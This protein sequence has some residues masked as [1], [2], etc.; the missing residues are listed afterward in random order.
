MEKTELKKLIEQVEQVIYGQCPT[1]KNPSIVV[2]KET[3]EVEEVELDSNQFL[4]GYIFVTGYYYD[5]K[6]EIT[7]KIDKQE[8][9]E[10]LSQLFEH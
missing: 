7:Y 9:R 3:L 10:C 8:L 6:N 4:P 5:P 1:E 2:N